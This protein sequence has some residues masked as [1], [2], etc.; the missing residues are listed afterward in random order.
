MEWLTSLNLERQRLNTF[1]LLS[2]IK[3]NCRGPSGKEEEVDEIVETDREVIEKWLDFKHV[4]LA[5]VFK[6]L[7]DQHMYQASLVI[8][9]RHLVHQVSSQVVDVSFCQ[10]VMRSTRWTQEFWELQRESLLSWM[11]TFFTGLLRLVPGSL[12]VLVSWASRTVV[13]WEI[14]SKSSGS[15]SREKAKDF[16]RSV[17]LCLAKGSA[18]GLA[19]NSIFFCFLI[20]ENS[21]ICLEGKSMTPHRGNTI[22]FRS[23]QQL[24]RLHYR[25]SKGF[26]S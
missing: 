21:L 12:E 20:C 19:T 8:W 11:D 16:V 6:T 14:G 22:L 5:Q 3:K 7:V 17:R 4:G 25:P 24:P 1:Q 10:R 18:S 9:T 26:L 13:E 15:R 2:A 23:S